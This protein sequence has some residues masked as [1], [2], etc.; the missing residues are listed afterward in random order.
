MQQTDSDGVKYK[1]TSPGPP[2]ST[3]TPPP[4]PFHRSPSGGS[5]GKPEAM[6]RRQSP[7]M[8]S[9]IWHM[10]S[11]RSSSRPSSRGSSAGRPSPRS[12]PAPP[13]AHTGHQ[14][15]SPASFSLSNHGA[16]PPLAVVS[17]MPIHPHH[18]PLPGAAHPALRVSPIP[19]ITISPSPEMLAVSAL[20]QQQQLNAALMLA[21]QQ[22]AAPHPFPLPV[23]GAPLPHTAGLLLDSRPP[24]PGL[25]SADSLYLAGAARMMNMSPHSKPPRLSPVSS[26]PTV[27]D[28]SQ[29]APKL[30]PQYAVRLESA[31]HGPGLLRRTP[32][33]SHFPT[34]VSTKESEV[35]LSKPR[36]HASP[37]RS[38][39]S[40]AKLQNDALLR[41]HAVSQPPAYSA[42]HPVTLSSV[43]PPRR[44]AVA[45]QKV[46]NQPI[47]HSTPVSSRMVENQTFF[48]RLQQ[49]PA[50]FPQT[51]SSSRDK[52]S[53][54]PR[55]PS[56]QPPRH[57]P[58]AR[59]SSEAATH[60]GRPP[61]VA[62]P[63]SINAMPHKVPHTEH[64]SRTQQ[65][66]DMLAHPISNL[67]EVTRTNHNSHTTSTSQSGAEKH[68]T[69]S[70]PHSIEEHILNT[71]LHSKTSKATVIPAEGRVAVSHPAVAQTTPS[72]SMQASTGGPLAASDS[73]P[74][75]HHSYCRS[76]AEV[77]R[78]PIPNG[79]VHRPSPDQP[80]V[81]L[82][83]K[84]EQTSADSKEDWQP[85]V[86]TLVVSFTLTHWGW[87]KMAAIFQTAFSNA[88]SL[89]KIYKFPLRFHWNVFPRVQLII[90]QHWF[91]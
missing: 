81:G 29:T 18:L 30:S 11:S 65:P 19:R 10:D 14:R 58:P 47:A 49:Q 22:R 45:V 23:P 70:H 25:T 69:V 51:V 15:V 77:T 20:E 32:P 85:M 76:A 62:I 35:L 33:P 3:P 7:E 88:F 56:P 37:Q 41:H 13:P 60:K 71:T 90:F 68:R 12:S 46:L 72:H 82:P 61:P 2:S 53:H 8:G 64:M 44:Q 80:A 38:S 17:G 78:P 89:L 31:G 43:P 5:G 42:S 74:S 73:A 63:S 84:V 39:V 1:V 21:A 67:V 24:P 6:L 59:P 34:P 27:T 86:S 26:A 16:G 54:A 83:I 57:V 91:R 40:P 79:E 36:H 9:Y 75:V 28:A 55:H 66:R 87:D 4:P 50:P 48:Q 52:R